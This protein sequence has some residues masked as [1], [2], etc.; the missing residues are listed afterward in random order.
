MISQ[1][2]RGLTLKRQPRHAELGEY[3]W[4]DIESGNVQVG[5][6]RCRIEGDKLTVFSIMIYPEYEHNGYAT[7]VMD[8]FKSR[9]PILYA[10]R[11]RF[12]A[13]EFW[14]KQGFVEESEALY[15]WHRQ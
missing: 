8:F 10:D 1:I 13:R 9:Y 6:S 3:D 11:V 15:V 4:F 12:T 5:K 14:T 2:G 7:A